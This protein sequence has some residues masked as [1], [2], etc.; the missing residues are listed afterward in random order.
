VRFHP[1]FAAKGFR[2]NLDGKMRLPAWA[3][4]RV[5]FM[6]GGIIRYFKMDGEKSAIQAAGNFLAAGLHL[7][8]RPDLHQKHLAQLVIPAQAGIQNFYCGADAPRWMPAFA[9][10]TISQT[11]Q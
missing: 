6:L 11:V 10:M 3:R 5:T 4:A 8:H 1:G 7:C 2:H 9:G